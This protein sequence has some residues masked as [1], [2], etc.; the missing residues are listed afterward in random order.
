MTTLDRH[1]IE[2]DFVH[3]VF[4]ELEA[5]GVKLPMGDYGIV[6]KYI[7]DAREVFMTN[8]N[9]PEYGCDICGV[10]VP[11]GSG[12]YY[13]GHRLCEKDYERQTCD[14]PIDTWEHRYDEDSKLGD[15]YTC[16][17]CGELTQVG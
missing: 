1:A 12:Q 7:E 5:Q 6:Y 11:D 4:Q 8:D 2:L 9:P 17:L 15:Y 10:H 13:N 3:S 14:H 16:G